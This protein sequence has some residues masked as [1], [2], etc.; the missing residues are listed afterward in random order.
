MAKPGAVPKVWVP[1][2]VSCEMTTEPLAR[3]SMRYPPSVVPE[4]S[5]DNRVC[6]LLKGSPP[7]VQ[8]MSSVPRS[9]WKAGSG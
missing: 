3:I 9:N 1:V 6:A 5:R 8:A 7:M 2:A 4:L